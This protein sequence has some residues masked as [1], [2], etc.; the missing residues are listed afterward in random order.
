MHCAP[1]ILRLLACVCLL[2]SSAISSAASSD[3]LAFDRS[4]F[5]AI[6]DNVSS[7]VEKN[8]YDA[9]MH[10]LDWKALKQEASTR[11]DNAQSVSAM[12]TAITI[13]VNKLDDSH[14]IFVPPQRVDRPEFGFQAKAFGDRILIYN[15]KKDGAAAAAGLQLGD[16]IITLNGY[17][18]LRENFDLMMLYYRALH[19]VG[20]LEMVIQRGQEPQRNIHLQAKVIEGKTNIDLTKMDTIWQMIREGEN[21]QEQ[22]YVSTSNEGVGYLGMKS[23]MVDE[24]FVQ[25]LISRVKRSRA[26]IIDLRGNMGGREDMLAELSGHFQSE[27]GSMADLVS[28]KKTEQLRIKPRAPSI[29]GP[30]FILVDSQSASAAEMFARYFQMNKQAVVIGDRTS[31][32]VNSARMFW[33]RQGSD[34]FVLYGVE[35]S[36]QKVLFPGG[37]QLE[38]HGVTPDI[39]CI[40]TAEDLFKQNDPCLGMAESMARKALA[41]PEPT[42]KADAKAN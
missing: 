26:T 15:L 14:T 5:H 36:T 24:G 37:E 28:R 27:P 1:R 22:F 32:R 25:S 10:G 13:L 7:Q 38:K 23:F 29:S 18:A 4:R 40:P 20:S 35:I 33:E 39:A 17:N 30:M 19:P 34:V 42:T 31:G 16:Q 41:V 6:L 2:V 9:N 12:I 11:I 21:N 8:F 3:K